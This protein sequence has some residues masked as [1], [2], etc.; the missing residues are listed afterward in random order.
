MDRWESGM[1]RREKDYFFVFLINNGCKRGGN[2]CKGG[3]GRE[4]DVK[5]RV[6]VSGNRTSPVYLLYK[7]RRDKFK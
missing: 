7:N 5:V 1:K 4:R 2:S 3:S 6:E